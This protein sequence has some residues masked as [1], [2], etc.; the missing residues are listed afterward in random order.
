M[1]SQISVQYVTQACINKATSYI[2]KFNDLFVCLC[3]IDWGTGQSYRLKI[4]HTCGTCCCDEQV[5][6]ER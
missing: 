2:L 1:L 5:L 3:G 4:W 6:R